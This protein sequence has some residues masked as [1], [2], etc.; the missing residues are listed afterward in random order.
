[1]PAECISGS[2]EIMCCQENF[3]GGAAA[4]ATLTPSPPQHDFWPL[5]GNHPGLRACCFVNPS[6]SRSVTVAFRRD[7]SCAGNPFRHHPRRYCYYGC[8]S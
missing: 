6:Q 8:A 1:V 4:R 7:L 5:F 3:W 2:Y